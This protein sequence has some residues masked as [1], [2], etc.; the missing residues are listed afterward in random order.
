MSASNKSPWV[1]NLYG[2]TAPL[3]RPINCN[4]GASQAIKR[5]EICDVSSG[6]AVPLASDKSMS[7][8]IL[9]IADEEIMTGDLAGYRNFIIP[10]PGDVFEFALSASGNPAQGASLYFSDSQTLATSGSNVLGN[11]LD[12]TIVPLQGKQSVNPSP[13][14]GTT[15]LTTGKIKMTIKAANSV[16]STYQL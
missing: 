8:G 13:D 1:C 10:L 5:G 16:W 9:V 11:V 3:K 12:E 15:I 14:A 2:R 6:H 4:S 7:A